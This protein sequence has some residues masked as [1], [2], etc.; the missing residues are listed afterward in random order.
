M[1]IKNFEI[2]KYIDKKKIFLI[3]GLNEGLK[4][5]IVKD[6]TN[7]YQKE[8][9]Y[10]YNE[11]NVF[12]DLDAFYNNL[13]SQS[14]F[15]KNK[16]III[17]EVS[18]KIKTEIDTIL[19][20]DLSEITIIL[21]S[22]NLEKK[23]KL[24]N[25]FEKEKNLICVPVYKDDNRTLL[26]IAYVFF[27]NKKINVSTETLN[28]IIERSS[29]DRKNLNNELQ[30]IENFIGN[31]KKIE[32]EDVMKLTKLSENYSI[33]KIVD[34]SL[35]R[36]LKQTLRALNEN[37]FAP[38][39]G[40]IIIRSYLSKSK[41][42]LKLSREFKKNQNINQTIASAKPPI[43]WKDK[44][45]VK[46]QLEIWSE[47]KVEDLIKNISNI[48]LLMKKNSELSLNILRNFII[49]QSIITNN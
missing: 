6:F 24:R 46:K 30:K 16:L 23:S 9:I 4:G 26:N 22:D 34:F 31:K 13:Y 5:E 47:K 33:N 14:F 48:E 44:E 40:I 49:E 1:I 19:S 41:R 35:A 43:F 15:D 25:L 3:Y 7:N 39:D 10:R 12:S 42:L 2:K 37:I 45:I 18:E 38:E 36:N 17:S 11:K 27:K 32:F 28:L 21:I 29:E 8:S 20:K